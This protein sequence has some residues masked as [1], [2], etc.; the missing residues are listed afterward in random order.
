MSETH[1]EQLRKKVEKRNPTLDDHAF[2]FIMCI[3]DERAFE[4]A[5]YYINHLKVPEGFTVDLRTVQGAS[6]MA[7][8]YNEAMESSNAKYK[9]YMHQD[10]LIVNHN[11]LYD[12][13]RFFKLPEVGLIGMV[14]TSRLPEGA[15]MWKNYTGK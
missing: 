13:L 3:N 15:I 1:L 4:E 12:L 11:F 5:V 6:G 2:C 7:S 14:G 9:I 10:V 8:G